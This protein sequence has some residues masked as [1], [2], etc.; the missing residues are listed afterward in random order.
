MTMRSN[1]QDQPRFAGLKEFLD[2][3]VS[4][5]REVQRAI[6]DRAPTELALTLAYAGNDFV[7]KASQSIHF[8]LGQL[9]RELRSIL[10]EDTHL[11]ACCGDPAT[12]LA[13]LE[14]FFI[15]R[16]AM[17]PPEE[18][19]AASED[20]FPT[21][22]RETYETD[23]YSQGVYFHLFNFGARSDFIDLG[24]FHVRALNFPAIRYLL[25]LP[26]L[27]T[28][29]HRPGVGDF[30]LEFTSGSERE[31]WQWIE[32]CRRT[33]YSYLR[34]LQY[35]KD[36]LVGIDYYVPYFTPG[37]VNSVRRGEG[38]Y[39]VGA[40]RR[41]PYLGGNRPYEISLTDLRTHQRDWELFSTL[42]WPRLQETSKFRETIARAG[43][44]FERSFS[45]ELPH[46]RLLA[47]AIALEALFSPSDKSELAFRIAQYASQLVGNSE[48]ERATIFEDIKLLYKKRSA[49]VHASYEVSSFANGTFVTHEQ[50]ERW[51]SI[52]RR[53]IFRFAVLLFRGL[54]AA[55]HRRLL[56]ELLSLS[57]LSPVLADGLR[58]LCD[59]DAFI[60]ELL[61]DPSRFA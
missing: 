39:Y 37:W 8:D 48:A 1:D 36:G 13:Y 9:E 14:R 51:S 40:P 49:L 31:P 57:S 38:I 53:S 19:R 50:V 32:E 25:G 18:Q 34:M 44:F 2:S 26:L 61:S 16:V 29:Y 33:A 7:R 6:R 30:Y 24:Q 17:R 15:S 11:R 46:D 10:N 54:R 47:L 23:S 3:W 22:Y 12:L 45:E 20:L 41:E 4:V 56:H 58:R 27:S 43:E 55:N 59:P 21:F 42:I 28:F 35:R 60:D 5:A 52:V